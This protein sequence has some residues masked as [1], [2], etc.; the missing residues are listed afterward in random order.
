[1][2]FPRQRPVVCVVSAALGFLSRAAV[3]MGVAPLVGQF[4]DAVNPR[5]GNLLPLGVVGVRLYS[6]CHRIITAQIGL[7][8]KQACEIKLKSHAVYVA[9]RGLR[10]QLLCVGSFILGV[11]QSA[12]WYQFLLCCLP[13]FRLAIL[14]QEET[15]KPYYRALDA[16][17][18]RTCWW[19]DILPARKDIF[20]ALAPHRYDQSDDA[21]GGQDSIST[22]GHALVSVF[23]VQPTVRPL[24]QSLRNVYRELH[25]DVGC[26]I[27]NNGYRNP[28]PAGVLML[29]RFSRSGRTRPSASGTRLGAFQPIA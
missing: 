6:L 12:L 2:V 3:A 23:S 29:T 5:P 27:P 13:F 7:L 4:P 25:E 9:G 16:F 20:D 19:T 26:P 8:W 21:A 1:V 22:P 24:P 17:L 14:A 18:K 11:L 28:G 10:D 15:R